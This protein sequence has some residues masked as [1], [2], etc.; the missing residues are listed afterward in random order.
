[1]NLEVHT[2]QEAGETL[3]YYIQTTPSVFT[4]CV[5]NYRSHLT[6]KESQE[7]KLGSMLPLFYYLVM[8]EVKMGFFVDYFMSPN[9]RTTGCTESSYFL[10]SL[11]GESA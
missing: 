2:L 5:P 8:L 11:L 1:M 4:V 9:Y 3:R 7:W 6:T 10:I